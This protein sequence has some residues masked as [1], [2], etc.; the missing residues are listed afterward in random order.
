MEAHA[1]EGGPELW[2]GNNEKLRSNLL[3]ESQDIE[4]K[5][6]KYEIEAIVSEIK[7]ILGLRTEEKGD[8]RH[9]KPSLT[10]LGALRSV[11]RKLNEPN[12]ELVMKWIKSVEKV[13]NRKDEWG[14]SLEK[15]RDLV[16]DGD[17]VW[18]YLGLPPQQLTMTQGGRER[19]KKQLWSYAVWVLVDACTRAHKRDLEEHPTIAT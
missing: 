6:S 11:L 14:G 15:V 17:S 1:T 4:S 16:K 13:Q 12:E 3:K 7:K 19:L 2:A 9:S 10:Q 8:L 5:N 18:R